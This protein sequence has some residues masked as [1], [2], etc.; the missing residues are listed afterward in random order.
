MNLFDTLTLPNGS[1]IPN[2]L[3]KAAMEENMADAA[4]A[5]SERLMRAQR[6]NFS[7]C[8]SFSRTTPPGP[9]MA[10]LSTITLPLIS[11]PAPPSAQAW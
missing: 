3:A 8:A 1:T 9:V 11:S 6:R 7:S 5:P 10:R 4:Q 2:R